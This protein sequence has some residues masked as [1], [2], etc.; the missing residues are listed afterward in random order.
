M[1]A[2]LKEKFVSDVNQIYVQ[3]SLTQHNL[4]LPD[5]GEI[6]EILVVGITLKKEEFDG[7]IIETIARQNP[8]ALLFELAYEEKR[9]LAIYHS[10]LYRSPWVD[11]ADEKLTVE[12]MSL[13][14]IWNGFME[15]I[16]LSAE[17]ATQ[18]DDL[19]IDE[20]LRL[21]EKIDKLEKQIEKHEKAMWKE[22]QPKKKYELHTLIQKEKRELEALT[23]GKA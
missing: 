2:A 20:R 8:H 22:K 1:T 6:K 16:A 13:D 12:G 7:K 11:V 10:K 5:E 21:Q 4:N 18:V 19:T 3:H 9:Q 17:K 14:A 23:H 15:Q